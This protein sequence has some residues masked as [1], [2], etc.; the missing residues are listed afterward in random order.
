MHLL[1]SQINIIFLNLFQNLFFCTHFSGLLVVAATPG[2]FEDGFDTGDKQQHS[3][4]GQTREH[5]ILSRG[6]GVSQLIV[7]VNKLDAAQPAWSQERFH[8][9]RDTLIPFLQSSGFNMKRVRFVPISGL[10]GANIKPNTNNSF[11]ELYKWYNGPSL[12]EAI[13]TFLPAV[14]NI[15]TNS[16]S[17]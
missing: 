13:D 11:T 10:T 5:I 4:T 6:L 7:A 15:G 8:H 16:I 1:V 2:E 9:I 17:I 3:H 12:V 14:R